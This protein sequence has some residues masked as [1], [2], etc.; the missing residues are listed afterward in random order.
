MAK[1][2]KV[3]AKRKLMQ[4]LEF[5][6]TFIKFKAN[7]EYTERLCNILK[8]NQAWKRD[9]ICFAN[10]GVQ[11]FQYAG[12][13]FLT[14]TEKCFSKVKWVINRWKEGKRVQNSDST[15]SNLR[16]ALHWYYCFSLWGR[17]SISISFSTT[18]IWPSIKHTNCYFC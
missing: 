14:S 18:I 5:Y 3:N 15:I 16:W 1:K 6:L 13:Q 8:V 2:Q 12:P 11:M 9:Y 17:S 4:Y 10:L 7:W